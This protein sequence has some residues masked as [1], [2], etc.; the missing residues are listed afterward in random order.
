MFL[1]YGGLEGGI[2]GFWVFWGDSKMDSWVGGDSIALGES[3]ALRLNYL[4]LSY[5]G[6]QVY[7]ESKARWPIGGNLSIT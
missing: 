4:I 6:Q 2:W 5:L 1:L 7:A 3:D